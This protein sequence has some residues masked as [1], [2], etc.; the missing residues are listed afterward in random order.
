MNFQKYKVKIGN[1]AGLVCAADENNCEH[2]N[3]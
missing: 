3:G 2:S 1:K